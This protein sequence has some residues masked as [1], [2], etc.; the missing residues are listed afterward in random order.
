MPVDPQGLL[1]AISNVVSQIPSGLL[2]AIFL[3]GPTAIWLIARFANPRDPAKRE[4]TTSEDLLWVC[5]S[6]RSINDDRAVRC[7][8]C[9]RSRA[10]ETVPGVGVAVGP[11]MPAA[12]QTGY[13]WLGAEATGA[14]RP[15]DTRPDGAKPTVSAPTTAFEPLT[16]EPLAFEPMPLEPPASEPLALE[17]LA[18]EPLTLEPKAKVARRRSTA[19][20]V[21]RRGR[22][23]PE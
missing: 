4:R 14:S 20:S 2:V 1:D 11:G 13:W 10:D 16:F 8:S 21:E 3:G 9:H 18:L 23:K 19:S 7:Y 6:C 17:P 5:A 12:A 15:A 22:R